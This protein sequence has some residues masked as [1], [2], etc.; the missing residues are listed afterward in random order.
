MRVFSWFKNTVKYH[1]QCIF[2]I[3]LY[4]FSSNLQR[5]KS[6]E[7]AAF[8]EICISVTAN[9]SKLKA[10]VRPHVNV[11]WTFISSSR[12][13]LFPETLKARNIY[14]VLYASKRTFKKSY[15]TQVPT[16]NFG[17]QNQFRKVIKNYYKILSLEVSGTSRFLMDSYLAFTHR[18]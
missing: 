8:V 17:A 5:K 4:I 16:L 14:T 9:V 7:K 6:F 13:L 18:Q 10:C 1:L 3:C 15:F 2:S 11:R 12:A